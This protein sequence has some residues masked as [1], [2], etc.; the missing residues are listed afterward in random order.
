MT[1]KPK[2]QLIIKETL[3]KMGFNIEVEAISTEQGETFNIQTDDS[4]ILIGRGGENLQ[5]LQHIINL[6]IYQQLADE[7]LKKVFI[8]I[9]GYRQKQQQNLASIA[10]R[11][12]EQVSRHGRPEVLRPMTG[13]ER[14]AIHVQLANYPDLVTESIG[15]DPNRRIVI[16]KKR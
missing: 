12:A 10:I 3:D 16:K 6:I 5:A 4:S 7:Q 2:T 11:M 9:N 15:Q 13:Y 14:R 1:K 8:D